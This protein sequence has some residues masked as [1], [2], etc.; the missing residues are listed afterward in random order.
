MPILPVG[1]L[2]SDLTASYVGHLLNCRLEQHNTPYTRTWVWRTKSGE[3]P[4]LTRNGNAV[5]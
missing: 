1:G 4:A 5:P 3:I 2:P